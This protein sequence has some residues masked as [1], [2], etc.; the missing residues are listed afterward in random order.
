MLLP[1]SQVICVNSSDI[2]KT[3]LDFQ[4]SQGQI[5]F[6][7]SKRN[8]RNQEQLDDVEIRDEDSN[9]GIFLVS[10]VDVPDVCF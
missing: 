10:W 8:V 5:I 6:F 2:I 9:W 1:I 4:E 3:K 7:V